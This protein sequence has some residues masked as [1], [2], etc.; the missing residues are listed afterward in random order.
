MRLHQGRERSNTS[1]APT[2]TTEAPGKPLGPE[3]QPG[4][5]PPPAL[6]LQQ[7]YNTYHTVETMHFPTASPRPKSALRTNALTPPGQVLGQQKCY[8]I[9][10]DAPVAPETPR[11]HH[12]L[13]GQHQTSSQQGRRWL[14]VAPT[15][16]TGTVEQASTAK[17]APQIT[18]QPARQPGGREAA[19]GTGR[20]WA[21]LQGCGARR[22][23][24]SPEGGSVRTLYTV[25]PPPIAA[26]LTTY[27]HC[28]H[29][30]PL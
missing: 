12:T 22:R 7:Q 16:P 17:V 15:A 10:G 14:Q 28:N 23:R 9:T 11:F 4:S 8:L 27:T 13:Q 25:L 29:S 19:D 3:Q 18:I 5:Q 26:I 6:V 24:T 1:T 2:A 21:T 30:K 20:E